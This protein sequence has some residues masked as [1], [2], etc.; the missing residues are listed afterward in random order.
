MMRKKTPYCSICKSSV[1]LLK[2]PKAAKHKN[3][4]FCKKCEDFRFSQQI[5]FVGTKSI[6]KNYY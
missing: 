5:I 2:P 3:W 4:A 6:S 1:I